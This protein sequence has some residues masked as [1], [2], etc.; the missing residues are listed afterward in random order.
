MGHLGQ[1]VGQVLL[2][3]LSLQALP[4]KNSTKSQYMFLQM[5]TDLTWKIFYAI[6]Y[7]FRKLQNVQCS[8]CKRISPYFFVCSLPFNFFNL[9]ANYVK[10][11]A[12]H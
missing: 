12:T 10:L 7:Y 9:N 2:G 8:V 3:P 11:T 1:E 5:Y 4:N 6:D